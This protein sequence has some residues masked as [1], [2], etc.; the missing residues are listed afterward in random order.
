MGT[1]NNIAGVTSPHGPGRTILVV[2]D[3]PLIRITIATYLKVSGFVVLEARD[4]DEALAMIQDSDIV[5]DLV[6]SD[7]TMPGSIDGLGLAKWLRANRPA[8]PIILTS[9]QAKR[10]ETV[11]ELFE[12]EPFMVKPYDAER[13]VAQIGRS[14]DARKAPQTASP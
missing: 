14:I 10:A 11:R 7:I 9:G 6:F 2:E 8:L 1:D 4:A 12:N 5:I 3:E 13:V